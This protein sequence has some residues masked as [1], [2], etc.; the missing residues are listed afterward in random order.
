MATAT[1]GAS[2]SNVSASSSAFALRGGKYGVN[3][4]ATF[5]GGS[6]KL[7]ILQADGSSYVSVSSATDFT[8]AGYG[9]VDLPPGQYR[10]TIATATAVYAN[11]TRIPT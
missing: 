10:F 5:G 4:V 11:V 7:Q 8:A 3:A 9:T 6:V 1:D 2:V